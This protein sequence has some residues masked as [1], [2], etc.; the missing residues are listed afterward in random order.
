MK[1]PLSAWKPERAV[2]SVAVSSC[3][4]ATDERASVPMISAAVLPAGESISGVASRPAS[5]LERI[6]P[7]AEATSALIH[8]T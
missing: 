7:P 3:G 2:S 8:T 4:S 5:T 1:P 6:S